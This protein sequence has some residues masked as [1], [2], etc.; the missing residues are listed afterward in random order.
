[1]IIVIYFRKIKK[2]KCLFIQLQKLF[3]FMFYDC[4]Q[5]S[6]VTKIQTPSHTKHM[7]ATTKYFKISIQML[8]QSGSSLL[9]MTTIDFCG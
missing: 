6:S 5:K 7:I 4:F 9:G 2:K 1:M 8:S 3:I